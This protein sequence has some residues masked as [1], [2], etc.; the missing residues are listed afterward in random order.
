MGEN[1]VQNATTIYTQFCN[2]LSHENTVPGKT[3]FTLKQDPPRLQ[4]DS[5]LQ[6][7]PGPSVLLQDVGSLKELCMV[8]D[9]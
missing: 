8:T 9:D 1:G 6:A 3:I 2:V 4:P 7:S 5:V